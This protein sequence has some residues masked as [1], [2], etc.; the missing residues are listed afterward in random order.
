MAGLRELFFS[1]TTDHS[2]KTKQDG[3]NPPLLSGTLCV[4]HYVGLWEGKQGQGLVELGTASISSLPQEADSN[5]VP[6]FRCL[7]L[8]NYALFKPF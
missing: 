6:V 1:V 5:E 8:L 4:R 2:A 7:L 3:K